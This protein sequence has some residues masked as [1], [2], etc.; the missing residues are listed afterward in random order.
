[1]GGSYKVPRLECLGD[2]LGVLSA[3]LALMPG[4]VSVS[5][6]LLILPKHR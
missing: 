4:L 2:L 5:K 6:Q 3:Q 1:M